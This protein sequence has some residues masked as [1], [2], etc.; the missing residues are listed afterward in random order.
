MPIC[1]PSSSINRISRTRIRS[2]TRTDLSIAHLR[3][4]RWT[5]L[6]T[7]VLPTEREGSPWTEHDYTPHDYA[8]H[9]TAILLP[10]SVSVTGQLERKSPAL[11]EILGLVDEL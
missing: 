9:G 1:E 6:E 11:D 8:P 4:K 5:Q 10:K 3:L 7:T 2:L